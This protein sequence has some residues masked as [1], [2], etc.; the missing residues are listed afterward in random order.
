MIIDLFLFFNLNINL[1]NLVVQENII[2]IVL[3]ICQLIV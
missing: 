3:V 2:I 1:P